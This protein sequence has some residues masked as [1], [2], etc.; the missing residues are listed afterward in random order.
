M[1]YLCI[2]LFQV[3]FSVNSMQTQEGQKNEEIKGQLFSKG[4]VG[5]LN[6]SKKRA[7]KCDHYHVTLG[8]LVFVC[9]LEKLKTPK[10][11]LKLTDL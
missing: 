10:S 9:F 7:K 5:I 2:L 6:S 3:C 1:Y 11:P 8:Q 4:L